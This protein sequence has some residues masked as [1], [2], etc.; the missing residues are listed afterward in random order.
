MNKYL[1]KVMPL[2]L[3]SPLSAIFQPSTLF[4]ELRMLLEHLIMKPICPPFFRRMCL[5]SIAFV[6]RLAPTGV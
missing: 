3:M 5:N 6:S 1:F 2:Y 4:T